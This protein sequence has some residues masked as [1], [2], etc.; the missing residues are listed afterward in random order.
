MTTRKRTPRAPGRV[1]LDHNASAPV[2]PEVTHELRAFLEGFWGNAGA[3]HPDGLAAR[4][5]IGAARARVAAAIGANASEVTFT[6]GGTESNNWA[7]FGLAEAAPPDRRHIV[8]GRH[9]HLSVV[10][11]V[12]ALER[13]GFEVTWLTP[14]PC[15][16]VRLADLSAAI[17]DDTLVVALMLANNETGVLQ[18]VEDAA[19]LARAKGA[20]LFVDAVC[21]VGKVRI[22][23]GSIGCDVLSLSGHKVHAPKGT[24]ALWVREGVAI[25][26]LIRG[27]G[28]QG[29]RR[30]GTENTMGAVALGAAMERYCGQDRIFGAETRALR[31]RLWDGIQALGIGAIRNGGGPDL[32]NTLSV[33]FPGREALA[34]QA[35]LGAA[36]LSVSAQ[37]AP[38]DSPLGGGRPLPSHVLVAMGA[39]EDRARESLRFSLGATTGEPEIATA[40]DVL[41]R[42]LAPTRHPLAHDDRN[43]MT[44]L[45]PNDGAGLSPAL[46]RPS[47]RPDCSLD[48]LTEALGPLLVGGGSRSEDGAQVAALLR[49]YAAAEKSWRR[50]QRFCE[51]TYSRNLVWRC[52]DFE[53]LLLCWGEGHVSPIH[54]HSGQQCWMAVL[55]GELEEVHYTFGE[56]GLSQG[57]IKSFPAGGVAFIDDDIALH[58]IRP[59]EGTRGVSL[60]LYSNPIDT[61]QI[62]CPD[63]G[64]PETIHVGYHS[65]R[66]TACEGTDPERIRGAWGA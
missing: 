32:P 14:A 39:S 33:W 41:D 31:D 5:A 55:E 12:E 62:F 2:T 20:L 34:L 57:R 44:D 17:R 56:N 61:C 35:Q 30:S 3:G 50:Y 38:S 65:V 28:Q 29:G 26:P 54:D 36:G 66:G 25:E 6:S 47:R 37:A 9:E 42:V 1:Y 15:G 18:P 4:D 64:K 19:R 53:L 59:K 40:L 8:V 16:A 49:D 10:R 63:T 7:L 43:T 60:H 27:C 48:R 58:Q 11:T 52:D 13:R 45:R 51:D 46:V 21:G 24:G 23:V 22:D